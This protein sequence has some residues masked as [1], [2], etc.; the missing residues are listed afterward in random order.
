MTVTEMDCR[1]RSYWNHAAET[2]EED[3]TATLVGRLQRSAV[4]RDLDRVFK[5]PQRILELNCGTGIDA[6]HLGMKG[7]RVVACD[8]SSRM[9]ELASRRAQWSRCSERLSFHTLA[10][11]EI[12]RVA[13]LGPFD[14]VFS[15]FSGLN[16]V[17]DLAAVR[18]NLSPLLNPGS[19]MILCMLGRFVPW[20]VAWFI[21]H[22]DWTAATRRLRRTEDSRSRQPAVTVR[23]PSVSTIAAA[24]SPDFTLRSWRG[25]GITLPPTY[26]ERW[27]RCFPRLTIALSEIDRF[28]GTVPVFR[29]M[30]NFAVLEFQRVRRTEAL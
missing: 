5:P 4:W 10:T 23:Y 19:P 30:A 9:I 24:F 26:L 25:I 20:E 18:R 29:H 17:G 13:T 16:C 1:N 6:V 14:G 8:I 22:R 2:Y 28:M 11:E 12:E 7:L 3:F 27:A 21:A 15:N